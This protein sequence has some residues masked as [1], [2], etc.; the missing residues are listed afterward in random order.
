MLW[1]SVSGYMPLIS[2]AHADHDEY[3]MGTHHELPK[4]TQNYSS[5]LLRFGNFWQEDRQIEVS[6]CAFWS[7]LQELPMVRLCLT[8]IEIS[9]GVV[10]R[11]LG[12]IP[13][14]A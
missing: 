2:A 11:E 12:E 13:N 8:I 7:G 4:D 3:C 5:Y 10:G 9:D 6:N 1:A 14:G